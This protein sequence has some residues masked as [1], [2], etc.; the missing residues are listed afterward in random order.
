MVFA[1]CYD[2]AQRAEAY[3]ALQFARTYY[4]AYRDLPRLIRQHTSGPRALD[5]GCGT[6]RSSR[7]LRELGFETIGVDIAAHM[8]ANARAS[9][10]GGDYRVI[11]SGD[12]RQFPARSFDL[13]LSAFTFDNIPQDEK[14]RLH[15][16]LRELLKPEGTMVSV[17][18]APEIYWHEWA[19]FST[20]DFPENRQA[21]SGDLVRIITTEIADARPTED[22]LCTGEAYAEI[23]AQA[24]LR[25]IERHAPLA[26]GDEPY[27]WVSETRIA[28]WV[29]YVLQPQ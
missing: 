19:S 7:F 22:I 28:P 27:A 14:V 20:Q 21:R 13:V 16:A 23:Y 25:V 5:F 1:N 2:D 3:S 9:D 24:G 11:A 15:A 6:G 10:P 17:V 4:L 8:V 18:S 12:F 29:I 26:V